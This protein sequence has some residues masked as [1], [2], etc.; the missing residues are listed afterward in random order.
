[1]VF[2]LELTENGKGIKLKVQKCVLTEQEPNYGDQDTQLDQQEIPTDAKPVQNNPE[3][4][5]VSARG[6]LTVVT[7]GH[8]L[9]CQRV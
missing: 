4:G 3:S 7:D 2:Q 5:P 8:G 6:L 1:M 9:A